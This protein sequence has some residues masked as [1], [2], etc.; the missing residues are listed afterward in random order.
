[1]NL[2]YKEFLYYREHKK[3]KCNGE[4]SL[5]YNIS[6]GINHL[7][8]PELYR[9][10][11]SQ[12]MICGNNINGYTQPAG[13]PLL[14]RG[15]QYYERIL[16]GMDDDDIGFADY[17]RITAGATAAIQMC[18]SFYANKEQI[19]KVLISGMSYYLFRESCIQNGLDNKVIFSGRW[20]IAISAGFVYRNW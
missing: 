14:V 12:S 17:V 10:M 4:I 8:M 19:N 9:S 18:I 20:V 16:A 5:R 13:H 3:V 6:D 7:P 15:I 2:W 1:M 11:I